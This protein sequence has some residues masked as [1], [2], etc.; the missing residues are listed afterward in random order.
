MENYRR[1]L[2]DIQNSNDRYSLL[3]DVFMVSTIVV[4]M[5]P[6]CTKQEA[7]WLNVVDVVTTILFSVDYLLRWSTADF[8]F[9]KKSVQSF[10]RYPF[11]L[12]AIVDLLAIFA[13]IGILSKTVKIIKVLRAMKAFKTLRMLRMSNAFKIARTLRMVRYSSSLALIIKVIKNQKQALIAVSELAF[14][15]ILISAIIIFNVEP[16]TFENFFEAIYWSFVS[17]STVGYGDLYP[18]TIAGRIVTMLGSFVGIAI[19][20]L[21]SAIITAGYMDA[22]REN[23]DNEKEK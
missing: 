13:S 14:G 16:I 2:Y 3:Y 18:V 10:I 23:E 21:P 12:M 20:S 7:A 11:S 15:Y 8:Q 17:L 6:L 4:S 5:L 22:L 19:V 1:R 9:E